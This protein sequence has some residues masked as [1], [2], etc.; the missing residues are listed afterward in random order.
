MEGGGNAASEAAVARGLR[1]LARHQSPDG[2]WSLD[3]FHLACNPAAPKDGQRINSNCTGQGMKN[4]IAGTAL[5]L[6]P[7][8]GAG[9]THKPAP[10]GEKEAINYQK[11]VEA[12]LR[13]LESGAH[14]GKIVITL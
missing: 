7:F 9:K 14:F 1:F 13:Y 2:H 4:D 6:L 10:P 3:Q 5:G 8:L 11:T 12:A